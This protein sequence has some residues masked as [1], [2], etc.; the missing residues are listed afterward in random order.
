MENI[1]NQYT[2]VIDGNHF[3][4][5][6]L[7]A[8]G[9]FSK[10]S[11]VFRVGNDEEE[12]RKDT[13]S[14]LDR[15]ST[16]FAKDVRNLSGLVDEI[17]FTIDDSQPWR[18]DY[19]LQRDYVA[20]PSKLDYKGTREKKKEIN[21]S[22]IYEVFDSF[23]TDLYKLANVK[24][25]SIDGCE[26]DDLIFAI[27]SYYNSKG[28]NVIIYSGDN[29]LKQ[30]VGFNHSTSAFTMQYQKQQKSIYIDRDTGL[31]IKGSHRTAI[32]SMFKSF[33]NN[34]ES[35]LKVVY[36]YEVVFDKIIMG[37]KGDNI[38][39]IMFEIK[40]YKTGKRI[41]KEYEWKIS[42]K[43]V[44]RVKEEIDYSKYTIEDLFVDSYIEKIAN[45]CIRNFKS[46]TRFNLEDVKN[47]LIMNINLVMLNKV[48]IP[49]SLYE[50]MLDWC[51]DIF[52]NKTTVVQSLRNSKDIL[53][54]MSLY[55]KR[56]SD[57]ATSAGIF[58]QIGL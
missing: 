4:H 44:Q 19:F 22:R 25:K 36:P 50:S 24:Y 16:I 12:D 5:T 15:L 29:D 27:S 13:N 39:P 46:E 10:N 43:D 28:K 26:A 2:L 54:N 7:S 51:E 31:H 18:K 1:S 20:L 55:D 53:Y 3:M 45:S 52:N 56:Q 33:V 8:V 34:T 17:I 32:M 47:N 42:E 58:K 48:T 23:V 40:K 6:T 35:K 21:W 14:F 57:G 37:D 30:C 38:L 11:S 41:G 49:K 9:L